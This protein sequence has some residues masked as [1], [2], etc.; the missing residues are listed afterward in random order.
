MGGAPYRGRSRVMGVPTRARGRHVDTPAGPTG[1]PRHERG[2]AR[3]R[4]WRH[5][6]SSLGGRRRVMGFAPVCGG[7]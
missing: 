1:G 7:P 4:R 2:D 3:R 6:S 5:V